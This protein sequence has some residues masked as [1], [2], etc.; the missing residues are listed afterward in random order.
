M[1][2]NIFYQL[3]VI[4]FVN[5]TS[6]LFHELV[7]IISYNCLANKYKRHFSIINIGNLLFFTFDFKFGKIRITNREKTSGTYHFIFSLNRLQFI[8][9]TLMGPIF[10]IIYILLI[11]YITS[12]VLLDIILIV[13]IMDNLY[14]GDIICDMSHII[15]SLYPKFKGIKY[16]FEITSILLII[17]CLC[18][19]FCC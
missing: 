4:L 5:D 3:L 18:Y 17:R 10:H 12:V 15:I 7:H 19:V 1:L 13:D 9:Y 8:I 6:S 16:R 2:F 14:P 11:K